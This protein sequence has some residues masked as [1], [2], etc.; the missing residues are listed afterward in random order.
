MISIDSKIEIYLYGG[1]TDMRKG[2]HGLAMV[3]EE[4]IGKNVEKKDY[5][6]LEVKREIE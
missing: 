4:K 5:S 1:S 6:Y 2:I 3:I